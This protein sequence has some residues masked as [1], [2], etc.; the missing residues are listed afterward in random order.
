MKLKTYCLAWRKHT[1]NNN[2]KK[3]NYGN[4]VFREKSR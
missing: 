1:N 3:S 4:K 2:S